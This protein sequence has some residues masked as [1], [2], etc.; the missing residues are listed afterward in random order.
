MK[1][2]TKFDKL[3]V[4][5]VLITALAVYV[6]FAFTVVD[7][8][9][10]T[11]EVFVDGELFGVYN[12]S[13]ITDEQYVKIQSAFG[14]NTLKLTSTGAEMTEASCKDKRDIKNGKISKCGQTIICAPNRVMVKLTGDKKPEVD[15][16]T[17]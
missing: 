8:S 11:V 5:I 14:E 6:C 16:V 12:L 9:P 3:I 1:S 10:R 15:R 13:E 7:S 17:Y 4:V 2:L